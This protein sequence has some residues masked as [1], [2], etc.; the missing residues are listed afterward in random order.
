MLRTDQSVTI[1][2]ADYQA[3][4]WS[5][6]HVSLNIQL[7][8]KHTV[9]TAVQTLAANPSAAL[10]ADLTT[11]LGNTLG[12]TSGTNLGTTSGTTS[13]TN[14]GA[15]LRT[16][17]ILDG[18]AGLKLINIFVNEIALSSDDYSITNDQLRVKASA[19]PASGPIILKIISSMI[20]WVSVSLTKLPPYWPKWPLASGC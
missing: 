11:E 6:S 17:L 10:N 9:I 19:I 3:S 8:P 12:A 5:C 20:A 14:L 18:D 16:D 1:R 2:R 4:A 15:K 13:G 7:D